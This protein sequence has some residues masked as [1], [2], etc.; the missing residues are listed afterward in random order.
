MF[1][2]QAKRTENWATV[3]KP[4]E[5]RYLNPAP[6]F[7]IRTLSDCFCERIE[8]CGEKVEEKK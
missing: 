1:K 3:R 5:R 2:E 6:S 7:L 4:K 8:G